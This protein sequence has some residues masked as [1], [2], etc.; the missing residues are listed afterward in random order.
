M[1]NVQLLSADV[2]PYEHDMKRRNGR[3]GKEKRKEK[4]YH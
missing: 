1:T 4:A 3:E 2:P